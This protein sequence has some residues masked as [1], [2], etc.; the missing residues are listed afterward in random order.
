MMRSHTSAATRRIVLGVALFGMVV[1]LSPQALAGWTPQMVATTGASRAFGH[2]LEAAFTNPAFLGVTP[3]HGTQLRLVGVGAGVASNGLG[4]DDYRKYNGATLSDNDKNDILSRIPVAGMQMTADA[5][6][7]AM[8]IRRG[9]LSVR[10]DGS[11]TGGGRLDRDAVELIFFGNAEQ[12]DWT[13]DDSDA[14]GLATWNLRVAYGLPVGRLFGRPVFAGAS[15]AYVRGLYYGRAEEAR[16]DLRTSHTGLAG[17]ATGDVYSAEGGSGVG[18]DLG[19]AVD[20]GSRWTAGLSV[21]NVIHTVQWS[22]NAEV[23]RYYL[24]FDDLTVDNFED[25]LWVANEI[26]ETLDGFR[27]G[28]P[29][30][31]RVSIG[32]STPRWR[33]GTA[34]SIDTEDRLS[35]STTPVLSAGV[36]H[37]LL[38]FLPVRLGAAIGGVSGPAFGWGGGLRFWR[39]E[40]NVGFR[41]D[42]GFWLGHG[43][44]LTAAMALDLTL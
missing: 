2:G 40:L 4:W 22:H 37:D 27:R 19:M 33:F 13:F 29:A 1:T 9:R 17:S 36:E 7:T 30:R 42:R 34:I 8:A 32:H 21:E 6:A 18:V 23:T 16:A 25:S 31:M 20:L 43:R 15:V 12:P 38:S 28:L 5:G 41:I 3:S 26:R 44:G 11:A 10:V 14:E 35:Y 39:T 24:Q